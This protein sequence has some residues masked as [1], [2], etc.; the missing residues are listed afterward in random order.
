MAFINFPS[1][2]PVFPAL[3]P[4]AWSVNKV[5]FNEKTLTEKAIS[6]NEYFILRQVIPRWEFTLRYGGDSWLRDQT[7]NTTPYGPLSGHVELEQLAGLFLACL[8]SYGEFYYSDPDDNSRSGQGVAQAD[9]VKT[10]FPVFFHWG[11]GPFTPTAYYPVTGIQ[12]MD[13][14]YFNGS[15]ISPTLYTLDSTN[16]KLVFTSPPSA[17]TVIAADFHFYF[18]CR[19]LN[20]VEEFEQWAYNLWEKKELKFQSVKP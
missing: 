6:G 7:Q 19:F 13:T 15:P 11:T 10:T 8:G 1:P 20:D 5:P 12:S 14:V 3:S 18:R 17:G 9:G 4:L 16:T 2:T